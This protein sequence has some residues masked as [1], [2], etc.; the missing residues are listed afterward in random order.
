MGYSQAPIVHFQPVLGIKKRMVCQW[1]EVRTENTSV[2]L[3]LPGPHVK[4][5]KAYGLKSLTSILVGG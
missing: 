5:P 1:M 4:N 3:I 2:S